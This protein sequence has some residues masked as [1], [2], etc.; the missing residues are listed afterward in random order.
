MVKSSPFL[1]ISGVLLLIVRLWWS[2]S[3]AS[4]RIRLTLFKWYYKHLTEK[5]SVYATMMNTCSKHVVLI[6]QRALSAVACLMTSD[7]LALEQTFRATQLK[8]CQLSE[9]SPGPVANKATKVRLRKRKEG[10]QGR[11]CLKL[12]CMLISSFPDP[13]A[14]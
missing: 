13:P 3:L 11:N 7:L 9:G 5:L 10:Q 2:C 4:F 8:L 6:L 14:V 1:N 12:G